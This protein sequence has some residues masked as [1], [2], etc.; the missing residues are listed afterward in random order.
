MTVFDILIKVFSSS[1]DTYICYGCNKDFKNILEIYD[2]DHGD[3]W[4]CKQCSKKL[5][6][7]LLNKVS[8]L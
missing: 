1:D 8:E 4:L 2:G 7:L 6:G 5:A 3:F